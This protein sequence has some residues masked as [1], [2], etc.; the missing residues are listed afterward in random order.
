MLLQLIFSILYRLSDFC[1]KNLPNIRLACSNLY[2]CGT[3][4]RRDSQ[5]SQRGQRTIKHSMHS[6]SNQP[7]TPSVHHWTIPV[8]FLEVIFA[9]STLG[10]WLC[11]TR[12]V[13]T[14]HRDLNWESLWKTF[15]KSPE[16]LLLHRQK[17]FPI[18]YENWRPSRSLSRIQNIIQVMQT[19]KFL[20]YSLPSELYIIELHQFCSCWK[21]GHCQIW[22]TNRI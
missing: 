5:S 18:T 16:G 21:R 14:K 1:N 6:L 8:P 15:S 20:K 9:G 2:E 11:A 7:C 12:L 17:R 4:A 10:G 19:I 13:W 22:L 3:N